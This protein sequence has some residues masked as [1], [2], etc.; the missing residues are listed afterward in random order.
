[1][2]TPIIRDLLKK[3]GGKAVVYDPGFSSLVTELPMP[4]LAI[5]DLAS[6]P[7]PVSPLPALPDVTPD[8][9]ALFFHTSGTT[10]GIPKPV[11]E[12]HRWLMSQA[13]VQWPSI[14]QCHPDGQQLMVNNIG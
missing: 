9:I 2:S 7:V 1:M 14:W 3:T 5:P 8:D 11:P 10:S 4:S 6:L 13:H 12:A